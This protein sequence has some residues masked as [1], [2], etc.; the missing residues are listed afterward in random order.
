MSSKSAPKRKS[1]QVSKPDIVTQSQEPNKKPKKSTSNSEKSDSESDSASQK[2]DSESDSGKSDCE[3]DSDSELCGKC[4]Q[5]Q[6]VLQANQQGNFYNF[7]D[8][9][10]DACC[11]ECG[12][13]LPITIE[14]EI[15]D[16]IFDS[17]STEVIRNE[18]LDII[19]DILRNQQIT[20]KVISKNARD[21]IYDDLRRRYCQECDGFFT[22]NGQ[23]HVDHG[24]GSVQAHYYSI[25]GKKSE[26][27]KIITRLVLTQDLRLAVVVIDDD[28]DDILEEDLPELDENLPKLYLA[29]CS[30]SASRA[31]SASV[32]SSASK[33]YAISN[34]A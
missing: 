16:L 6:H 3:S 28:V 26:L 29:K 31:A 11:I 7:A 27:I 1:A 15:P 21:P 17:T 33:L 34:L 12:L 5:I 25:T 4:G 20:V 2:S 14:I 10:T 23:E 9:D 18:A 13:P 32:A 30:P 19:P 24:N 22:M 8:S